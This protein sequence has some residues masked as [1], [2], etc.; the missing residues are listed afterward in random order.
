M[1]QTCR[2]KQTAHTLS[3]NVDTEGRDAHVRNLLPSASVCTSQKT[4]NP[5]CLRTWLMP[6]LVTKQQDLQFL[7]RADNIS[8]IVCSSTLKN[9]PKGKLL[10]MQVT[11]SSHDL[12]S[13]RTRHT[14]EDVCVRVPHDRLDGGCVTGPGLHTA[15]HSSIWNMRTGLQTPTLP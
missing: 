6:L 13:R 4:T 10:T 12:A 3:D 14:G 5:S 7:E 11:W 2:N 9:L 8:R 1:D 15:A